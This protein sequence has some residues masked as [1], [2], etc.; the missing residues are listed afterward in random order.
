MPLRKRTYRRRKVV[1]KK[2][3]YSRTSKNTALVMPNRIR[4]KLKYITGLQLTSTATAANYVYR[5]NS[6]FD[7]DFT[8]T[9]SQPGGFDELAAIY[10][11]YRVIS[12]SIKL[13]ARNATDGST[14]PVMGYIIPRPNADTE[15]S[16]TD[17]LV[18]PYVKRALLPNIAGGYMK[19]ISNYATT[20]KILGRDAKT[21]DSAALVTAN[22]S[23][24][25]FWTVSADAVLG[26]V[27]MNVQ[28]V[29]ELTYYVEFYERKNFDRS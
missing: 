21:F 15:A 7:P 29:V 11:K 23:L 18:E 6:C 1:R 16:Y 27:D 8:G 22:P 9:G 5:G 10:S 26:G 24:Q 25:W 12:S 13:L 20:R 3:S 14:E 4:T 19:T 2:K 28:G 17:T